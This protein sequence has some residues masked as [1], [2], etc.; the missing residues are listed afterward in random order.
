[1][2]ICLKRACEG[3]YDTKAEQGPFCCI[4]LAVLVLVKNSRGHFLP[5]ETPVITHPEITI[6]TTNMSELFHGDL[7]HRKN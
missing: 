1:M 5:C 3:G 2:R 6:S 4:Y 7:N